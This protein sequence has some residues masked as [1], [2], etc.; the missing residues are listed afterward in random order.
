LALA[1]FTDVFVV[2]GDFNFFGNLWA[3]PVMAGPFRN[4]VR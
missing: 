2:Q 4:H 3:Q 1:S